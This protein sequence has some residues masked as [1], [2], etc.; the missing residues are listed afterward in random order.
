VFTDDAIHHFFLVLKS[1]C[2]STKLGS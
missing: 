2:Q 1:L